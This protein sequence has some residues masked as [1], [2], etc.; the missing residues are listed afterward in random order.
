M[1]NCFDFENEDSSVNLGAA[2]QAAAAAPTE[3]SP[4]SSQQIDSGPAR[5]QPVVNDAEIQ[6]DQ[7]LLDRDSHLSNA[8][9]SAQSPN[10]E[11]MGEEVF[12]MADSGVSTGVVTKENFL[13]VGVELMQELENGPIAMTA[14][15]SSRLPVAKIV[16]EPH[17]KVLDDWRATWG[18]QADFRKPERCALYQDSYLHP[19]FK[20]VEGVCHEKALRDMRAGSSN[21]YTSDVIN[22]TQ[23]KCLSPFWAAKLK[24]DPTWTPPPVSPWSR[25]V[26]HLGERVKEVK[27]MQTYSPYLKFWCF[28]MTEPVTKK[29]VPEHY[30]QV[31]Y[32]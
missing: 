9:A 6:V 11:F 31:R 1:S 28:M 3:A 22:D 10:W 32:R 29:S 30:V 20:L 25:L 26:K 2:V 19:P 24:E 5:R 8:F 21:V 14:N 15:F 7:R 13:K 16:P 18:S 27:F 4:A 12:K 17:Q 23:Q